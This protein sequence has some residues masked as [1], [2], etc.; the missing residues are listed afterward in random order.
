MP[1]YGF[2]LRFPVSQPFSRIFSRLPLSPALPPSPANCLPMLFLVLPAVPPPP[3]LSSVRPPHPPDYFPA[4]PPPGRLPPR[5]LPPPQ[6]ASAPESQAPHG[7]RSSLTGRY[8]YFPQA[9]D[10]SPRFPRPRSPALPPLQKSPGTPRL[11]YLYRRASQSPCS[12]SRQGN[13]RPDYLILL[14]SFPFSCPHTIHVL[15]AGNPGFV[16]SGNKRIAA[17][18]GFSARHLFYTTT[19]LTNPTSSSGVIAP[20]CAPIPASVFAAFRS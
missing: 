11:P 10:E 15:S 20:T 6:T 19:L 18:S 3:I 2:R 16:S 4:F 9:A 7:G 1:P 14:S 17:L 13:H 8:R 5:T 12:S